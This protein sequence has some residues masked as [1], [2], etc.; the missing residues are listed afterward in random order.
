MVQQ[1]EQGVSAAE[2]LFPSDLERTEKKINRILLVGSCLTALYFEQFK[3]R[4]PETAF[5]YIPYNFVSSLP[6]KPPSPV[7]SYDLQYVQI[8]LRTLLSDR[9]IEGFHFNEPGFAETILE[10]AKNLLDVMLSAAMVYN[11]S[12]GL[13]TFVSNF[14]VPQMSS[15]SSLR[16]KGG[17]RDLVTI[18]H[19]LND[20]LNE[21]VETYKNAYVLD[22]DSVASA[23]GKRY[24]LDDVV[25]F[26]SHGGVTFQDWD[27]FGAIARNEPIPPLETVYP[28][29]RDEFLDAAYRQIV[30]SYRTVNQVDQVKA[31]IFDLDNTL[32]RGQLAE[33]YRPDVQPW[34]RTDG[35]PLGVWEAIHYL[36]ARGILVAICSKNDYETVKQRW[37]DVVNPKFVS[38]ED[39]ASLKINWQPKA[40]NIAAIC[41]EF[42]IKPKSVVF[43]DDNPVERAAVASAFPDLRVMGGNPYLTR[44]ILLWSAETQIAQLTAESERREDMIRGQIVRE[45]TRSA[46]SREEFL[47]SLECRVAFKYITDTAQS[48][49]ARALELTNK[50]NQFNT[51]G[52]RWAFKEVADF[53]KEGGQLLAFTVQ[54]KFTDYG[55]VGVLFLKKSEIVQYVMS[56]RVLGMEVEEFVVAEAV[57]LVRK[58]H[59]NVRVTASVHELPDNTPCRDV[60]L[61]VGFREDWVSEGIHYYILD[62]GKNPK[63]AS[64]IKAL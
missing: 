20:Y 29:K 34:P 37:D 18:V 12:H 5:D 52:K 22:V 62:E 59:G 48:E 45:E 14:I 13:L 19:H 51:S 9:V 56:C 33:H 2:F 10:D 1:K 55:L 49:F 16:G 27:D 58:A 50:T 4:H 24:V 43:V 60:Y 47:A 42:N 57:A 17:S 40:E 46:M 64:H 31:V 30:T 32:W 8:P 36:R 28:I 6:P 7:E 61:R 35:W 41:K 38:L 26:Y 39:F 44:R 63:A 15:A 54:D 25:Y 11:E 23:V 53:L 3:I 21:R